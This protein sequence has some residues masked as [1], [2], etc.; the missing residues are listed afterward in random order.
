[1]EDMRETP[2]LLEFLHEEYRFGTMDDP[3]GEIEDDE[4]D[5]PDGEDLTIEWIDKGEYE[6]V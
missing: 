5:A 3:D 1:M 6:L 2:W 4:D